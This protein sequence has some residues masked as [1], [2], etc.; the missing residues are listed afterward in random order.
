M[1]LGI[2]KTGNFSQHFESLGF[3]LLDVEHRYEAAT[4]IGDTQLSGEED[5]LADLKRQET[6]IET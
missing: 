5:K 6:T 4:S 3:V 2:H 1:F